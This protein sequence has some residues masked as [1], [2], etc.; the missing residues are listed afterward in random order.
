MKNVLPCVF[1]LI[2]IL[3]CAAVR[4]KNEQPATPKPANNPVKKLSADVEL[5]P[6]GVSIKNTDREDFPGLRVRF[7]LNQSGS[8]D[9]EALSGA[10]PVGKTIVIPYSEFTVGT[11]RFDI[12]KTKILTVVLKTDDGSLKV[13][14]CPGRKCQPS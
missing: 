13:F 1:M 14:L 2:G 3:G 5:T 7:N 11:T 6:A 10:V 9:G 4:P 8:D 12:R